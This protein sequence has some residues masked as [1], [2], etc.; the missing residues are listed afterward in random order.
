MDNKV[1]IILAAGYKAIGWNLPDVPP[2]C[3]EAL[4]PIGE[5]YGNTPVERLAGQL[6][7]LGYQIFIAVGR[8][9]CRYTGMLKK[10]LANKASQFPARAM[11]EA[12]KPPWTY[13]RLQYVAQ[14]GIPL[15]MPEPDLKSY[16]NSARQSLDLIG[17][18]WWDKMVILQCDFI[19]PDDT[20]EEMLALEPNCQAVVRRQHA[21]TQIMTPDATRLYRQ[22]GDK[23]RH[24]E[25]W[26][27][28][29]EMK[30]WGSAGLPPEGKEFREHAPYVLLDGACSKDL[31][32]PKDYRYLLEQWLPVHG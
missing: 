5:E 20:I 7:R 25:K 30:R 18:D 26:G 31:D 9:G 17:T 19:W 32:A 11:P 24:R 15:L 12:D 16:D 1:A 23:F 13:E 6:D 21:I 8:P 27:W 4:L 2:V 14:Y 3:P 22:L 29:L 10:A 28:N